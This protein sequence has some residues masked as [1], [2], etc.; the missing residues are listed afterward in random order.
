MCYKST[1]IVA[2]LTS[3][4]PQQ[5]E[6]V[7]CMLPQ[8]NHCCTAYMLHYR[9]AVHVAGTQAVAKLTCS[10]VECAVMSP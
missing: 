5:K 8:R 4:A 2:H 7:L 3:F 6:N 10:T 1:S 9:A